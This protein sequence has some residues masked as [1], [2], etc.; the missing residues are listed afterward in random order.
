VWWD[1][2]RD[3]DLDCYGQPEGDANGF[4]R[5]ANGKF[6][7]VAVAMGVAASPRPKTAG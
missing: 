2:D 5:Q 3:G 7:D 1:F 4:Y 6:E